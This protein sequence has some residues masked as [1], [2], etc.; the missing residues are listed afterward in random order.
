[1]LCIIY[2]KVIFSF[3]FKKVASVINN[4]LYMFFKE[5]S[6]MSISHLNSECISLSKRIYVLAFIYPYSLKF[7]KSLHINKCKLPIALMR[8]YEIYLSFRKIK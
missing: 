5:Q 4:S 1:M 6:L 2:D 3:S 8:T 7:N